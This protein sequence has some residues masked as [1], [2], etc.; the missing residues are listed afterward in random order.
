MLTTFGVTALQSSNTRKIHLP[1]KHWEINYRTLNTMLY[2]L[3]FFTIVF[4]MSL[5]KNC[6]V[7]LQPPS[8]SQTKMKTM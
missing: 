1:S 8:L 7:F 3:I 4:A 5:G 2:S 6:K